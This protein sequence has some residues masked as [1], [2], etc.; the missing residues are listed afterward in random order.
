M[1]K[2]LSSNPPETTSSNENENIFPER[3]QESD[4]T[5]SSERAEVIMEPDEIVLPSNSDDAGD[6]VRRPGGQVALGRGRGCLLRLKPGGEDGQIGFPGHDGL[7]AGQN[8]RFDRRGPGRGWKR[9]EHRLPVA[10]DDDRRD[11]HRA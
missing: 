9:E 10:V 6:Q 5:D 8:Q 2:N 4:L 11:H 3:S 7:A 1:I